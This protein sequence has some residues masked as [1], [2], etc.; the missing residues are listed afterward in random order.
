LKCNRLDTMGKLSIKLDSSTGKGQP[1][2]KLGHSGVQ[3]SNKAMND[4]S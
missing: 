2:A 4:P 3:L 1:F